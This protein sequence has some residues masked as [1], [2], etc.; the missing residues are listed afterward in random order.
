MAARSENQ[1]RGHTVL[2]LEAART[3]LHTRPLG[4]KLTF[5]IHART[6]HVDGAP[7]PSFPRQPFILPPPDSALKK[8]PTVLRS[9]SKSIPLPVNEYAGAKPDILD[10]LIVPIGSER[11]EVRTTN[12]PVVLQVLPRPRP[13]PARQEN[14]APNTAGLLHGVSIAVVGRPSR[15]PLVHARP[16]GVIKECASGGGVGEGR[17]TMSVGGGE[18][19]PGWVRGREE[20]CVSV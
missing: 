5:F 1:L 4:G 14:G 12:F 8:T 15:G 20:L 11:S 19:G 9:I 17:M 16:R 3:C 6:T 13:A 7:W 2:R 10:P 18:R